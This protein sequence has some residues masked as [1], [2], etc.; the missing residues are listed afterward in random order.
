MQ[1]GVSEILDKINREPNYETRRSMLAAC[2][3]NMGV[4]KMLELAYHPG[5][6]FNL[7]EGAPPYKPCQ[8]ADQQSMLYNGLRTMY[9][10]IGEGNPGVPQLKRE[11]LFVGFLESLDPDDAKLVLS[12]KEKKIPYKNITEELVRSVFPNMLPPKSEELVVSTTAP[13]TLKKRPGRP[14]QVKVDA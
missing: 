3:K 2:A 1:L 11:A 14:A 7:P 12:V 13:E 5:A 6:H 8:F 10:F 9:L 4:M